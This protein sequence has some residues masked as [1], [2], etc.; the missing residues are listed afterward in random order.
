MKRS[1]S[2]Y[3]S[4]AAALVLLAT[5]LA[6]SMAA[7][8]ADRSIGIEPRA[9][10]IKTFRVDDTAAT[11]VVDVAEA[12][13]P[14]RPDRVKPKAFTVDDSQN[15]VDVAEPAPRPKKLKQKQPGAPKI[16][17]FRVDEDTGEVADTPISETENDVAAAE[18][19]PQPKRPAKK[20]KPSP[21]PVEESEEAAATPEA[22]EEEQAAAIA[23]DQPE[24]AAEEPEVA[25]AEE[26]DGEPT[27]L[28][29]V[30]KLNK[31]KRYKHY[32]SYDG[33][34]D[35]YAYQPSA[36]GSNCHQNYSY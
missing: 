16:Q 14:K 27:I 10:K 25:A 3:A 7:H 30:S 17:E 5:T 15:D 20:L 34:Q 8:A 21:A 29:K 31:V 19:V 26:D 24:A 13:K 23:D 2:L 22:T 4:S 9:D 36:Y 35:D 6:G 12:E 11:P 33:V 1:A 28:R 18:P 32:Q